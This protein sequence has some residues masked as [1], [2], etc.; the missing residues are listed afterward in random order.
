MRATL[1]VVVILLATFSSGCARK[2]V[3]APAPSKL[4][5]G[6]HEA[7]YRDWSKISPC[8]VYETTLIADLTSLDPALESFLSETTGGLEGEWDD[9]KLRTLEDAPF[10]LAP[11]VNAGDAII[12]ATSKCRVDGGL[13]IA[14]KKTGDLLAQTHQR[15]T[16]AATLVPAIKARAGISVWKT[17]RTTLFAKNRKAKCRGKTATVFYASQDE[18]GVTEWYFCDEFKVVQEPQKLPEL[19]GVT[20][21]A[22]K[23][24][25]KPKGYLDAVTK[26][27]ATDI[28][29]CPAV[30]A[31]AA[32]TP[33]I[34]AKK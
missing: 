18:L 1:L 30:L 29:R 8:D 22:K 26:F 7:T 5:Y 4:T 33:E 28:D 34:P 19:M 23:K 9:Q 14:V 31:P 6:P 11:A 24:K 17:N 10:T 16:E 15:I 2:R 21:A 3:A 13:K 27:K 12:K 32:A 25:P 20:D